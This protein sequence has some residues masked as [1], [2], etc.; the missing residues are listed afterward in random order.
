[1]RLIVEADGEWIAL[2]VWGS[3]A[4]RL[5]DRDAFIG[6]SSPQR[7]Q[8]Q[9]LVVQ[10]RRFTMLVDRGTHPNLASR[11]LGQMIRRKKGLSNTVI[12]ADAL[13]CQR[14]TARDIVSR[15][16][17]FIIQ[18]KDNQ[19]TVHKQAALKTKDVTPLLPRPRKPTGEQTP[20]RW[21]SKLLIRPTSASRMSK[22]S[23]R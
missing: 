22:P 1:M 19:K 5:K 3:A 21:L 7:A 17:E 23:S 9:K 12:T 6:W 4:Y 14:Q 11:M 15:G 10:N 18:A 16:G 20:G 8:R 2:F 13:H